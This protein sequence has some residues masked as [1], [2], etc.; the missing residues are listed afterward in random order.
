MSRI[1]STGG[2]CI[3]A[4]TGADTPWQVSQHALGQTPLQGRYPSMHWADTHLGRH[5]LGRHPQAGG[6]PPGQTPSRAGR[7]PPGQTPS[8]P[9][10][11]ATAADGTH[12]TGMH[13]CNVKCPYFSAGPVACEGLPGFAV[14]ET[15]CYN[16]LSDSMTTWHNA[17]AHCQSVGNNVHLV[18]PD[19]WKVDLIPFNK[20]LEKEL[21]RN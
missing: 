12:L 3:P 16:G 19:T 20:S 8:P 4:C 7:H 21:Y 6:H 15:G 1:L 9:R 13:S 5:P 17:E 14:K 10:P 2:V 11:M 18:R